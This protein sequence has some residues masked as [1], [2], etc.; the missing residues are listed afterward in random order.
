MSTT[1]FIRESKYHH[2]KSHSTQ[3]QGSAP[4]EK[5]EV[6]KN[7][8]PNEKFWNHFEN[9]SRKGKSKKTARLFSHSM[10]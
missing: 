9:V 3:N 10:R 4:P 6:E 8:V 2:H 5:G 7:V 1:T